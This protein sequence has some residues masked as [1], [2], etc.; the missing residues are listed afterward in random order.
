MVHSVRFSLRKERS[1]DTAHARRPP[2]LGADD[3]ETES[4]GGRSERSRRRHKMRVSR[5]E[6]TAAATAVDRSGTAKTQSGYASPSLLSE[7][8][9]ERSCLKPD[10]TEPPAKGAK[11][12]PRYR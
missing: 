5:R 4:C 9:D 7:D 3:C 12:D 11:E 1:E 2:P 10:R 8:S 6:A